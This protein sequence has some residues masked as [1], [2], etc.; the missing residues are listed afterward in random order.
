MAPLLVVLA[1]AWDEPR[2]IKVIDDAAP[3]RDDQRAV[4]EAREAGM[5]LSKFE[6]KAVTKVVRH[7]MLHY[8]NRM[9]L[10]TEG[11]PT[12]FVQ[13]AELCICHRDLFRGF[14]QYQRKLALE[15]HYGAGTTKCPMGGKVIPELIAGELDSLYQEIWQANEE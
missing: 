14:T 6:P 13:R 3:G 10:I 4:Q 2:Y 9:V 7:P 15:T 11:V 12:A 8:Y 5:G 1:L